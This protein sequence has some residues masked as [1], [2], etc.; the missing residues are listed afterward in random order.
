MT[1]FVTPEIWT[2]TF[3]KSGSSVVE[4]KEVTD[5]LEQVNEVT[6]IC[7]TMALNKDE[8]GER[9]VETDINDQDK[10]LELRNTLWQPD[11]KRIRLDEQV[12]EMIGRSLADERGQQLEDVADQVEVQYI[13]TNKHL[14]E[15]F[16]NWLHTA[17]ESALKDEDYEAGFKF[18]E[19]RKILRLYCLERAEIIRMMS[20]C[21]RNI[22][23]EICDINVQIINDTLVD[24]WRELGA[25]LM[26]K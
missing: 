22:N 15:K 8:G 6:Q 5:L 26:K 16:Q 21:E 18:Q 3:E 24:I 14:F 9:T 25:I 12:Q 2:L 11:G 10:C 17:I 1:H 4:E 23:V 13:S 20:E 7:Q 19:A